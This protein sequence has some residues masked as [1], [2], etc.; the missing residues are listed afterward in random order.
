MKILVV[1]RIKYLM[2]AEDISQYALAKKLGIS[3]S[4]ICNWLNGKK[5]PSI[6]SLWKLADYFGESVDYII[7]REK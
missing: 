2:D 3:Q 1:E 6:E 4:T 7:G 5:E